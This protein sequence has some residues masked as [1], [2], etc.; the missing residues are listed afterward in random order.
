[1][2]IVER[3]QEGAS[4]APREL[5]RPAPRARRSLQGYGVIG[6]TVLA[7]L[8][9]ALWDVLSDPARPY[10]YLAADAFY[11]FTIAANWVRFGEP[12]FDQSHVT[13]GFH[14]L[15]QWLT[16][17]AEAVIEALG[18]SR[19]A[20]PPVAVIG[21]LLL[22][23]LAIV[24]LGLVR[25]KDGRL[26]PLFALLPLGAWPLAISPVWW[27]ARDELPPHL[28]TPLFGTFWN[29]ANGLESAVLVALFAAVAYCYVE[30]PARSARG[31]L[32]FGILLGALSLARL[33]HAVFALSIAG[34][35]LAHH[36]WARDAARARLDACAL[37][38]W[39]GVLA[40]YL[41]YNV[42]T[43]GRAMP[44][45]GAVKSTFPHLNSTNLE[46]L[47]AAPGFQP[48][49][50]MFRLG[51]HG[52]FFFPAL[53]ALAYVP[54]ALRLGGA[55]GRRRVELRPGHGRF[56]QLMLLTAAGVVALAVYDFAF[57]VGYQIGEWYAPL[58]VLFVT[59]F[60]LQAAERLAARWRLPGAPWL[61]A[62]LFVALHAVGLVSFW[63]LHRL[64]AWGS[65]YAIFCLGQA[66]EVIRH[67]GAN[68]PKLISRD[69]GIVGFAT[70]FPTTSGTRLAIDPEGAEADAAGRFEQLL[71]ER[72]VDRVTSLHYLNAR[73]LRVGERS[74]RVQ[75]F[76]EQVLMA[77]PTR[78]YEVEYVDRWFG[79]LRATGP[80]AP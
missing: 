72:G 36:L 29:F 26:S 25:M 50:A 9:P 19:F 77:R 7:F 24:L 23:S 21:G 28:M 70:G 46:V 31:A 17:L 4:V 44:V 16:A 57:V 54:F 73:G 43:V 11:Y 63:K 37:L 10:G 74:R 52:S 20:L 64:P 60:A 42:S 6:A 59:L 78:T 45:S 69:D 14:P 47:L 38:G 15:W 80:L 58:S 13:N 65:D 2:T 53:L 12:S 35:P 39:V 5:G 76:A 67:Y 55:P 61:G 18:Y 71:A 49:E 41:A 66:D 68:P 22:L 75:V 62:S 27:S 3:E 48:R 30:R 32:A 40:L 51:R 1:M 33:D 79:I 56:S 34:L 8:A